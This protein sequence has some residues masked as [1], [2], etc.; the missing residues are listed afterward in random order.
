M[1]RSEFMR[2]ARHRRRRELPAELY[3][4]ATTMQLLSGR[5]TWGRFL[6]RISVEEWEAAMLRQAD[7]L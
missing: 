6:E 3:A 5:S 1:F 2:Y 7:S 4:W